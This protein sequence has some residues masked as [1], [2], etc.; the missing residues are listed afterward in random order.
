MSSGWGIFTPNSFHTGGVQVLMADGAVRFI[1]NSIN[2]GN[3]G[4]GSP[5]SF[6]IW[7]AL[8]TINGGE[9]IGAF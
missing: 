5:P 2:C 4:A 7:G 6:G 3:Y 9:T 1:S 8:G